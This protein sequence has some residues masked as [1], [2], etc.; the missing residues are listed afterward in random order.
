MRQFITIA[1]I[2]A[3]IACADASVETTA[4]DPVTA[5]ASEVEITEDFDFSALPAG[6]Y[7]DENGHAYLQFPYDH[8][9][10]PRHVLRVGVFDCRATLHHPV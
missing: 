5:V 8:K 4:N 3:L 1:A 7:T 6:T 9:C 2:P 10:D